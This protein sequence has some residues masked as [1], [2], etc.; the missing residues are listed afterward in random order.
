MAIT[1]RAGK[2]SSLT[3]NELDANFTTLGLAHGDTVADID[4][5]TI[6]AKDGSSY[7]GIPLGKFQS[8][9]IWGDATLNIAADDAATI[10]AYR[11]ATSNTFGTVFQLAKNMNYDITS[12]TSTEVSFDINLGDNTYDRNLAN[13]A[14][15][16]EDIVDSSGVLDVYNGKI[17]FNVFNKATASNEAKYTPMTI[18]SAETSIETIA[19]MMPNLPTSDPTNAGQLWNDAGTLKVSAG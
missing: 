14:F 6:T 15:A 10:T 17:K 3:H 8:Y 1:T 7:N 5:N 13:M 12:V 9:Q 11:N 16:A 18:S 2:G 19:V 4:V